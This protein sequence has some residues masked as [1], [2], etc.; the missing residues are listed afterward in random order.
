M[1]NRNR[2]S[3]IIARFRGGMQ[4]AAVLLTNIHLP[5]FFKGQI[6][7]GTDKTVCVPGLNCYSCPGAAGAC[8]IGAFQAVVG[9]SRFRFSYY[10]TGILIL[11]GVL[12]GRFICGFLCPFG[13]FQDL[14]HKLPTPKLSTKRLKPLW[15]V[16]YAVLLIMVVLLPMLITNDL[17][18][19]NPFFCK[20]ICPQGVLGGALP[21]ALAND[22]IR[23]ALGKLFTQ[24]LTILISVAA[25]SAVFYRPFC[26][27]ICPLGA[28]YALF[29]R[30][31]LMQMQVDRSRCVACG[32]CAKACKMDVDVTKTPNHTEYIRCGMCVRACPTGAV[33]FRYGLGAKK[34]QIA[35]KSEMEEQKM[36]IKRLGSFLLALAMAFALA[37]C[38][39]NPKGTR[40]KQADLTVDEM[41]ARI[42]GQFDK[43]YGVMDEHE[44]LWNRLFA[45]SDD[46]V[47]K[48][49]D[50]SIV[51]GYL[52]TL[53]EKH[54][55]LL[56]DEEQKT[57]ASD[58]EKIITIETELEELEDIYA[59][60]L[61]EN[62]INPENPTPESFPAFKGKD[63]DGNDVD[64]A[65]LFA[66]N[67]V[68]V[69]NFWFSGCSTCVAELGEL[70]A[71]NEQLKEKGGAVIGIN[72]DTLDGKKA[73]TDEAKSILSQKGASYQNVYFESD[74]E[75]GKFANQIIGFPTTYV[76][77]SSGKIV[78][79]PLM[80][81]IDSHG[82][83]DLLKVR[84]YEALGENEVPY[85]GTADSPRD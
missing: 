46:T 28:F 6:Y 85:A 22:G 64:S 75:A 62:G 63:L 30:V 23:A 43:L 69:V 58:I 35:I 70:N 18:M 20:Y 13:W 11:F 66:G 73:M 65:K 77:D 16:K 79:E 41:Q 4:A 32:R 49:D 34:K 5:N 48:T 36:T 52:K 21:L 14:L 39:P 1:D 40:V 84:I 57:L 2:T 82:M 25:L 74:S 81:G 38:G 33:C 37:A 59:K 26:K 42:D 61:E 10:I 45:Q 8:P 44:E 54:K 15:F 19:G 68:T 51:S 78:G 29:N 47:N 83:L 53:V 56:S 17:G 55:S 71:L 12:F 60:M 27:W 7:H 9:S 50:G 76:V 31:S 24:K 3:G 72:T 80:G 67:K